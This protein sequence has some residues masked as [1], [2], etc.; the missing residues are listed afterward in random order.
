MTKVIS[1]IG[2]DVF[3]TV[4]RLHWQRASKIST[5]MTLK[6]LQRALRVITHNLFIRG[7]PALLGIENCNFFHAGKWLINM[8]LRGMKWHLLSLLRLNVRIE[9]EFEFL[10]NPSTER[11]IIFVNCR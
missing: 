11:N 9:F 1:E 3:A 6:V 10:Q 2:L 7:L 8:R 4:H 5:G